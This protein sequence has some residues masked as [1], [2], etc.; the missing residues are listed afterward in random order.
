[1]GRGLA[2]NV[3]H[4]TRPVTR[5]D[6]GKSGLICPACHLLLDVG[7][8]VSEI[9]DGMDGA[10]LVVLLVCGECAQRDDLYERIG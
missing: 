2:W 9:P 5:R 10:C 8:Y 4:L 1:M 7:D 6:I 3:L